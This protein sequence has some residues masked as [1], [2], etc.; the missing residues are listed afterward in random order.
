M[1]TIQI[2]LDTKLLR[3]TDLAAKRQKVNRSALIRDALQRHLKRLREL[4]LEDLDRRGYLAKPQRAEEY[5]I[6]EDAAAW[7]ERRAGEMSAFAA[8]RPR[9]SKGRFWF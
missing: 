9:I 8:S 5:R 4:E 6:W 1:E 7:P 3:A 2:V